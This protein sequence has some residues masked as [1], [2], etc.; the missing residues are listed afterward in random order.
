MGCRRWESKTI[1]NNGKAKGKQRYK[2]KSCGFN[3]VEIGG[4]RGKSIDKQKMAI[5]LYLEPVQDLCL[6]S[7]QLLD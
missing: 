4:R 3:F 6:L 7:Y 1:V 5:H 2:C